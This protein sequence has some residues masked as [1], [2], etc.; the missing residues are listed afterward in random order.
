MTFQGFDRHDFETFAIEGL[1][2]RMEAIRS[3]IQ[4]KFRELGERLARE[5]SVMSGTEMFLHI[6]QHARRSVNPPQDTWLAVSA[7]KRGYKMLPHFQVGLFDD[8]VF[9]WLAF[10]Y[11]LPSKSEIAAKF[12]KQV[13]MIRKAVPAGFAVSTDHM[14]KTAVP[15]GE[16]D[17]E[18]TLVRFRDV[19]KAELLIGR[20]IAAEDPLLQDGE[21]FTETVLKTFEVLMPLYHLAGSSR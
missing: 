1:D 19:K 15:I 21:A 16:I 6:A 8:H 17:L 12:L 3:R 20:Q 2:A 18:R 5:L 11:E 7:N 14:Q 13:K 4:P 10:I 9:V